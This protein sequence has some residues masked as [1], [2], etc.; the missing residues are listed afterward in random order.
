MAKPE[1]A[2]VTCA[3]TI[4][5]L[6]DEFGP[7]DGAAVL[8]NATCYPFGH[9]ALVQAY[10]AIF[11]HRIMGWDAERIIRQVELDLDLRMKECAVE[12]K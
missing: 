1:V 11:L 9:E 4:R 6:A 8:M 12:T 5:M 2:C 7:A 10:D 3:H